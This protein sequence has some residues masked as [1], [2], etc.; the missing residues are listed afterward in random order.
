VRLTWEDEVLTIDI[1]DDG[2][3]TVAAP[4]G[5]GLINIRERAAACGGVAVA[6]PRV[7]GPGFRVNA[8]FPA[9]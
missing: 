9:R 7:D 2:L 4:A 5:N 1:T 8:R 3:G 6:G